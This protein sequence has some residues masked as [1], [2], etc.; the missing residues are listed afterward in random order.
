MARNAKGVGQDLARGS[1]ARVVGPRCLHANELISLNDVSRQV[2]AINTTSIEP[3]RILTSAWFRGRPVSEEHRLLAVV[4][5]IPGSAF[6]TFSIGAERTQ[7][8]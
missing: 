6:F 2:I 1:L 5:V 8:S 7:S 3:D 4:N